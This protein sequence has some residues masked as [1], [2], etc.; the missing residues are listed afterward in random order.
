MRQIKRRAMRTVNARER[1]KM[2]S[3]E[4]RR[5]EKEATRL[6]KKGEKI[7]REIEG[8]G[9]GKRRWISEKKEEENKNHSIQ[10]HPH[11]IIPIKKR[12]FEQHLQKLT[13]GERMLEEE[14]E[15]KRSSGTPFLCLFPFKPSEERE[16]RF[17]FDWA[18]LKVLWTA[19]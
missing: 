17:S 19:H 13:L 16:P 2:R 10:L 9:D 6:C 14:G 4:K 15:T 8:S 12:T 7:S 3:R 1:E 5:K 11:Y 18:P